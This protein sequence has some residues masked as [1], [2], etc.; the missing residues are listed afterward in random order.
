M[1]NINTLSQKEINELFATACLEGNVDQI[2]ELLFSP[3]LKNHATIKKNEGST[4]SFACFNGHMELVQYLLTSPE[5]QHLS[6]I[7]ADGENA[8]SFAACENHK[9]IVKY[10]LTSPD[11]KEHA[12]N[13]NF[14]LKCSMSFG[15]KE[16]LDYLIYEYGIEFTPELQKELKK[17]N[18]K[19]LIKYK[20]VKKL[21]EN[22]DNVSLT[23][24]IKNKI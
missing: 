10:L 24:T 3:E 11:L 2:K 7:H 14:A 13:A 4:L 5:V 1:N 22:R 21:F 18:G 16:T 19:D 20:D 8:L 9:E 17:D 12:K 15:S 6:D 23:S